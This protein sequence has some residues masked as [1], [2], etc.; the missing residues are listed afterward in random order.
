MSIIA[1]REFDKLLHVPYFDLDIAVGETLN[2]LDA[3]YHC[4]HYF[5][6]VCNSWVGGVLV[7]ELYCFG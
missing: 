2:S 5:V 1:L 3:V 6:G 7:P 4:I